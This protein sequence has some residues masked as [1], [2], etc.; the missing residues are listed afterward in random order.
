[1]ACNRLGLIVNPIAGMG[2]RVGL[3]GTDGEEILRICREKGAVPE[4]PK[5]GRGPEATFAYQDEIE[6]VTYPG[7]M[8]SWRFVKQASSQS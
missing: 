6:I 5:S 3:K 2:G 1:M 8:E 7:E 4:A